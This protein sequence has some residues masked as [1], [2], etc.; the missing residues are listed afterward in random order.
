MGFPVYQVQAFLLIFFR[1]LGVVAFM[2][3]FGSRLVPKQAK[4]GLALLITLVLFPLIPV[5]GGALPTSLV[6][7]GVLVVKELLVGLIIGF[8]TDLIFMGVQLAGQ[9][10]SLQ[11]GLGI[12]DIIDP[13]ANMQVA[14]IGRLKHFLALLI[15]LAISGHHFLLQALA[16]SFDLVPPLQVSFS[17]MVV[18]KLVTMTAQVFEIAIKI[19]A[20]AM[21]AL[22][23]TNVALGIIARTVPQ[24]NVFIVGLPLNI[25]VG[26]LT[27]A[28]SFPFFLYLFKRLFL[29]L[30]QDIVLILHYL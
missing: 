19:G 22:F 20:P 5:P 6:S 24:M 7:Y 12:A 28:L 23:L 27:I 11:M 14:V 16:A 10:V 1:V 30:Q 15:F 3:L 13:Q 26:L 9:L 8:A 17:G 21:A 2:P 18:E 29:G 25:G 4:V